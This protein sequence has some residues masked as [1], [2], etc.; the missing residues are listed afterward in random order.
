MEIFIYA[1]LI[2]CIFIMIV[3]YKAIKEYNEEQSGTKKK[4][5][6]WKKMVKRVSEQ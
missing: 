3:I 2:V 1:L 4:K 6:G 5:E